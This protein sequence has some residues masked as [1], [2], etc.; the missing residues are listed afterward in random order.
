MYLYVLHDI[1]LKIQLIIIPNGSAV[2]R[3]HRSI[4]R[5][6]EFILMEF[7]W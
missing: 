5:N 7:C 2:V 6:E 1:V 4:I 3:V